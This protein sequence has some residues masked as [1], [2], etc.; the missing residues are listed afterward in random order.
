MILVSGELYRI[1]N[2]SKEVRAKQVKKM[3]NSWLKTVTI[4][5]WYKGVFPPII[6]SLDSIQAQRFWEISNRPNIPTLIQY[7]LE[8]M[9][10]YPV[11]ILAKLNQPTLIVTPTFSEAFLSIRGGNYSNDFFV[12]NWKKFIE[13][14]SRENI[15]LE[16]IKGSHIFVFHDNAKEF[17]SVIK[18]F[19]LK[20]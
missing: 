7:F 19:I 5:T 16:Q 11:D 15:F 9:V 8:F 4:K 1:P 20:K 2:D 3:A 6:Y 18:E 10:D 13:G 12:N 14:K 17:D